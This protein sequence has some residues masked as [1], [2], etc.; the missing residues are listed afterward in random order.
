MVTSVATVETVLLWSI[1]ICLGII[2]VS[3]AVS[4]L[5]KT[6]GDNQ[7]FYSEKG[8]INL[9]IEKLPDI[10]VATKN[11]KDFKLVAKGNRIVISYANPFGGLKKF[12]FQIVGDPVKKPFVLLLSEQ[13]FKKLC[14]HLKPGNLAVTKNKL[15]FNYNQSVRIRFKYLEQKK[16]K[17]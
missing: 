13:E 1:V 12:E 5:L 3:L 8:A 16:N 14:F 2:F 11:C 7:V 6:K 9:R 4:L 17:L 10:R 15:I